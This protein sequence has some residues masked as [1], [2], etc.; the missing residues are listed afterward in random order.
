[1]VRKGPPVRSRRMSVRILIAAGGTV[2]H[3]APA[4]TVAD[5]LR[6]RGADVVFAGTPDRAE[7]R[8]VPARGYPLETF[9]VEGFERRLS[10]RLARS[11]GVAAAAPVSCTRILRRV[12][13]AVVLGGGGYVSGPMIAAAAALRIPAV[14]TEADGH[15]GLAN[16]LASPLARRILLAMP[17]EGLEGPRYRVVGRPVDPRFFTVGRDEARATYGIGPD[18]QVVAAF[19]GSLGA[20]RLNEAVAGAYGEEDPAAPL[21]L[22]VTGRGKLAGT[23]PHDRLR[24]FEYCETM[25]ELLHAADL[26]V[27]RAGG[28]VWEVAAAGAPAILVPWAGAAADHQ[29]ANAAWFG[30]GAVVVPDAEL[31]AARLRAEV[32]GLLADAPRR[33]AMAAAMRSLAQPGAADAVADEVLLLAEERAA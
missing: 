9:R 30:D 23:T 33:A 29:T 16:R 24:V 1:M 6:E 8:L 10:A 12:R 2:G 11:V 15:L 5:V 3:V 18:E 21:V 7:A 31:D 4:L 27:C 20:G 26:V 13:P 14:L 17:I 28:S 19:G 32:A 22:Q 25:P